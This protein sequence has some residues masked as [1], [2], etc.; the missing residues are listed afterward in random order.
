MD[1]LLLTPDEAARVLGIG[2][3]KL[4]E[5]LRAGVVESVRIWHLPTRPG[6]G[7]VRLRRWLARQRRGLP[8]TSLARPGPGTPAPALGCACAPSASPR[9]RR[10]DDESG[11]TRLVATAAIGE[12]R[13]RPGDAGSA[14]S[15]ASSR[16]VGRCGTPPPVVPTGPPHGRSPRRPRLDRHLAEVQTDLAYGRW[17]DP[18]AGKVALQTYADS[19]LHL[20]T[21]LAPR[22]LGPTKSR[23][24][25]TSPPTSARS[26]WPST[27]DPRTHPR[28][29]RPQ[30]R[31]TYAFLRSLLNVAV[32]DDT[33]AAN[34]CRIPGA[35]TA[36]APERALPT[37]PQVQ[38]VLEELPARYHALVHLAV[39]SHARV[40]ELLALTR[41]RLDL[42]AEIVR[43]DRQL[44]S[45]RPGEPTFTEPKTAA[46]VRTVALPPHVLPLVQHHLDNH[47]GPILVFPAES[48]GVL[49]RDVFS[50]RWRQ[51]RIAP[52][53][54]VC[55]STTCGISDVPPPPSPAPPQGS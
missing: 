5:L 35:G 45:T 18:T 25:C 17:F 6:R 53:Y 36:R 15:G 39:W 4:Y 50:W 22:T 46:G 10:D 9:R 11:A 33:L 37:L 19:Y 41:D 49:S 31:K 2:R 27:P 7:L 3:S 54:R 40:G 23:C 32:R 14:A 47:A 1:K 48:G 24:D 13:W 28:L 34:P 12:E 43:Y 55:T 21:D 42:D 38:A 30:A 8:P 16:D 29:V 44:V 51:A 26:N 20:R 52:A